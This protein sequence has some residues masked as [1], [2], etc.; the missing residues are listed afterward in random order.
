V[1]LHGGLPSVLL[2][3]KTIN[4]DK[5]QGFLR[6]KYSTADAPPSTAAFL[7]H[8]HKRKSPESRAKQCGFSGLF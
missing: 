6:F 8:K 2:R 5:K 3:R 1:W 4:I 7:V